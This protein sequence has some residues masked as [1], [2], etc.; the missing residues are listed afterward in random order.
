MNFK[1]KEEIIFSGLYKVPV[2]E[3]LWDKGKFTQTLTMMRMNNQGE[4]VGTVSEIQIQESKDAAD[5]EDE[6][7]DLKDAEGLR[8]R[9]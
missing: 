5:K 8:F 7:T 2:I 4:D 1:N 9:I 6:E 3:S